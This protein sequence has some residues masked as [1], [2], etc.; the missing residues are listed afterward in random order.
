LE[1]GREYFLEVSSS[2]GVG[3]FVILAKPFAPEIVQ[4]TDDYPAD[5][6]GDLG[7]VGSE[8]IAVEGKVDFVGDSDSFLLDWPATTGSASVIARL[9]PASGSGLDPFLELTDSTGKVLAKNDNDGSDPS[10]VLIFEAKP[11]QKLFLRASGYNRTV[12]NY[13]LSLVV[14]KQPETDDFPGS[15]EGSPR[16]VL[17]PSVVNGGTSVTIFE[18]KQ[19][20][21]IEQIGDRDFVEVVSHLD[22]FLTAK[23][24]AAKSSTFNPYLQAFTK[25]D[26]GAI[27][28]VALDDNS[29]GALY[30]L[31]QIPVR[32]GQV[33]YLQ[34][35]G[36]AGTKGNYTFCIRS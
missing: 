13:V 2:S 26:S 27:Q 7:V 21:I 11:G 34:S 16:L 35:S 32:A 22:G 29:A 14:L 20:G 8:P 31:I 1:E 12:G 6:P 4:V 18:G 36:A 5:K 3:A 30:S 15:P 9:A 19:D 33:V 25:D 23:V 28:L 10:S 17:S 24:R